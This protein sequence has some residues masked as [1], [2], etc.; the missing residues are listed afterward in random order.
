MI[1]LENVAKLK[2]FLVGVV[3]PGD[4]KA[5]MEA[6]LTEL[7]SLVEA[8]DLDVVGGDLV[9]LRE[10][11]PRF[12]LTS[13]KVEEVV[14]AAQASEAEILVFDTS[15]SPSQQRNWEKETG[16]ATIDR[17]EVILDIF[18]ER[19]QTKEACLQV[20]LAKREYQLPR[21]QRA[22]SHLN[23]QRGGQ[24]G[25]RDAGETQLELD[26]RETL[27]RIAKL[28]KELEHVRSGREVM[29]KQ[30]NLRPIPA[31]SIVGYT[32]AGKSTL[33]NVLT[34]AEVYV[35]NQLFATL[36]PTS[37]VTRL[38]SG[39]EVV[40]TDTVGFIRN[41][42]HH[43]IDSFRST[44][45][46]A[47][48]ADFLILVV[49]I[50]DDDFLNHV[51]TTTSVLKDLGAGEKESLVL[52]NKADKATQEQIAAGQEY[53]PEAIL[54]SA[55]DK[56]GL[57]NLVLDIEERVKKIFQV[58]QYL[59]PFTDYHLLNLIRKEGSVVSEEHKDIGTLV[60]V[61][62][63]SKLEGQLKNFEF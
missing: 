42:P 45:E 34:G 39:T 32:N 48:I 5:Q 14:S 56:V 27:A 62:L 46:E 19:A 47:I 6:S 59:I 4:D 63:S 12:L 36:D 17:E 58:K 7:A 35:K 37:R 10:L 21:L 51:K 24:K 40:L 20:E 41:L 60:T 28:K 44:L 54:V 25:T 9:T 16:I 11:K 23:R 57:D 22:W 43:L 52:F 2:A 30:R 33:L 8:I 53:C 29:R 61:A 50:S 3:K 1:E 38:P 26:R 55:R 13:G 49:D 31:I 15:L 18:A